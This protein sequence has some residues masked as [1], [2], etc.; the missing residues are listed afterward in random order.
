MVDKDK[1]TLGQICDLRICHKCIVPHYENCPDCYG[2]GCWEDGIPITFRSRLEE[3]KSKPC[4]YCSSTKDGVPNFK[5][6]S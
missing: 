2:L 4:P 1:L 3:R 6:I 5:E